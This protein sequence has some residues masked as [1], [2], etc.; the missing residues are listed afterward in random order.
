MDDIVEAVAKGAPRLTITPSPVQSLLPCCNQTDSTRPGTDPETQ[1]S[2]SLFT[3]TFP[4]P[5]PSPPTYS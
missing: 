2:D 1:S 4:R 3:F 5:G